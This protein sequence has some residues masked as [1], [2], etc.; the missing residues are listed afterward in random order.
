VGHYSAAFLAKAASP[1]TPLWSLVLAAQL[2]DIAWGALV[3]GGIE[4]VR[5]DLSFPSN[6]LDFYYMPYTHSFPA[7]ILWTGAAFVL[8]RAWL[9]DTRPALALAAV[10][11]SHWFLDLAVHQPDL[12]LW[13]DAYKVGFAL[14]NHPR[15]ALLLELGLLTGSA[16]VLRRAT[17]LRLNRRPAFVGYVGGLVVAH[18]LY[19]FAP[20]PPGTLPLVAAALFFFLVAAWWAAR[21]E[22]AA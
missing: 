11:A 14:W 1:G 13:D 10:V 4:R 5:I 12:P 2:V 8:A 17:G 3:L 20:P 15:V 19:F 9:R 22:A 21:V 18:L 6:P 16:A 7:T